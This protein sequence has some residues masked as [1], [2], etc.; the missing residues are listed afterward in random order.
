MSNNLYDADIFKSI[1]DISLISWLYTKSLVKSFTR[2]SH[3]ESINKY[4]MFIGYS[5]SGK[6]FLSSLLDAHPHIVFANELPVLRYVDIGFNQRQIFHLI[7]ENSRVFTESG[8]SSRGYS[9]QV[10]NQWQGKFDQQ[11]K[12]IG[13]NKGEDT[14]LRLRGRL[15]MLQRLHNTIGVN[16]KFIHFI[17]NPF[18]NI[19]YMA[20][21]KSK[22]NLKQCIDYY[23]GLCET[24]LTIKDVIDS[25]DLFEICYDSFVDNPR[26][27]LENICQFLGLNAPEDYLD[28]CTSIV[29]EHPVKSRYD[30]KWSQDLIDLVH[31]KIKKI[32]FLEGYTY[33]N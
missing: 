25:N 32:P 26:Y 10:H 15:W 16:I 7:L 30:V 21:V 17:R 33:S 19:S 29:F 31:N 11:I 14:T 13:D 23:F 9:Y 12:V 24:M 3:F 20:M 22:L 4:C 18:D 28:D 6:T 1:K 5:K 8:R 2:D 27:Y